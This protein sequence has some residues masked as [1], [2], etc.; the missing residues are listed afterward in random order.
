[1]KK[2]SFIAIALIS[3]LLPASAWAQGKSNEELYKIIVE[4][5]QKL[6][7][8]VA[9]IDK[10]EAEASKAKAEAA[11]AKSE[12]A[13]AKRELARVKANQPPAS[14]S[15]GRSG[16]GL[17]QR[18]R[19]EPGPTA[20]LGMV[21]MRPSRNNLEYAVV[22]TAQTGNIRGSFESVDL[23]YEPGLRL[24]FG[25][26]FG[27]GVDIGAQYTSLSF[28]ETD[29]ISINTATTDLWGIWLHPNAIIDDNDVTSASAS[30]NFD[31]DVFDLTAGKSFGSKSD[32]NYRLDAGF[33]YAHIN[34][35]FD[36]DYIQQIDPVN[37]RRSKIE[38]SNNF[39][40][41]GPKVGLGINW[42]TGNGF[43]LYGSLAGSVLVGSFATNI[44]EN[45]W[46]VGAVNPTVRVDTGTRYENRVVPVVEMLAGVEYSHKLSNGMLVGGQFGYEWQNW[47]NMA[48]TRQYVDDVD[49]Q[50]SNT[51]TTDLGFDGFFLKGYINF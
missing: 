30:Y 36:I 31:Y 20:S 32:L 13:K 8:A 38:S 4:M 12:A 49:S 40:G 3:L 5:G 39:H 41:F 2:H 6:D 17:A 33:R 46:H 19:S 21:Y 14:E 9:K 27:T 10:V 25:Y 18:T 43:T 37:S 47:F 48:T 34:Q 42:P 16:Y 29:S 26:D 35:G 1:V 51:D 44:K 23:G 15:T 22:D 45:D 11:L 7:A 24:N 50:L 28:N